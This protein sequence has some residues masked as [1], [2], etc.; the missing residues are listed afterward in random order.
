MGNVFPSNKDVHE[1]FDLKGSTHGRRTSIEEISRNPQAVLKDL[2]W[3][4]RGLKLEFGP[5][6]KI[7]FIHQLHNDVKVVQINR[8][9]AYTLTI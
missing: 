8:G 9:N 6:K 3:I 5:S 7:M 4:E 2:N 1:T